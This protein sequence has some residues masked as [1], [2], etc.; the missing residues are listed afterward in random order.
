VGLGVR[1]GSLPSGQTSLFVG[2]R[3][4]SIGLLVGGD[5][6][7]LAVKADG[8]L[9]GE[10][11]GVALGVLV[12]GREV[13]KRVGTGVPAV[14]GD[15]VGTVVEPAIGLPVGAFVPLLTGGP[16]G[17]EVVGSDVIGG[18]VSAVVG[19]GDPGLPVGFA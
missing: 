12:M 19:D 13:G 14:I 2:L 6:T 10:P 18:C 11:V 3:V 9:D 15:A 7:G 16:V 17:E 1:I 4:A 5:I 8:I